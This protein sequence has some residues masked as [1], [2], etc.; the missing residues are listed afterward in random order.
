MIL[1]RDFCFAMEINNHFN[2]IEKNSFEFKRNSLE[3]GC[4]VDRFDLFMDRIFVRCINFEIC[5]KSLF[6][7]ASH[8]TMR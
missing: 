2:V 3:T 1:I 4:V 6:I 7:S 5:V 8:R